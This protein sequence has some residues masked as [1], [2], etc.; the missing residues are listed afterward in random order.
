MGSDL[1]ER[2]TGIGLPEFQ[3]AA[4]AA[5]DENICRRDKIQGT[6]P[7]FVSRIDGLGQIEHF[8]NHGYRLLRI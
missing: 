1:P 6:D 3:V 4:P 7:V 8:V 2:D 5:A